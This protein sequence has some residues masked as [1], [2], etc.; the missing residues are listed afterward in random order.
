MRHKD[1]A[2][3]FFVFIIE[4]AFVIQNRLPDQ[5]GGLALWNLNSDLEGEALPNEAIILIVG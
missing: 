4:G 2:Q 1:C 5:R 3:E